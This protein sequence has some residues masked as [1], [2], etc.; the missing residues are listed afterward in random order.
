MSRYNP[1]YISQTTLQEYKKK[2]DDSISDIDSFWSKKANRLDW[3]KKWNKV[4]DVDY[5]KADIKWFEGGKLNASYNCIDRNIENGDGD[6][7]AIVWEG[8]DSK[9]CIKI[10]YNQL[11]EDVSKFANGLNSIGVKKDDRVCI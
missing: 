6:K 7:T 10:S 8:N 11:L 5:L 2:Y 4:S 9:E 1:E 3:Y